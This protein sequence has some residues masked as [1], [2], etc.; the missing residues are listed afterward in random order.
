MT[1]TLVQWYFNHSTGVLKIRNM[2][3]HFEN[4]PVLKCNSICNVNKQ[5]VFLIRRS[6]VAWDSQADVVP[7]NRY[8]KNPIIVPSDNSSELTLQMPKLRSFGLIPILRNYVM[9]YPFCYKNANLILP[10]R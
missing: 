7:N 5:T 8:Y 10:I 1:Q 2:Q 4:I 3:A 9:H 6:K